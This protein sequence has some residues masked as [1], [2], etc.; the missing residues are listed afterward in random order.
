MVHPE[1][2]TSWKT[3]KFC[4]DKVGNC[5][6]NCKECKNDRFWRMRIDA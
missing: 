6:T 3:C 1:Y 2:S 4:G 5:L